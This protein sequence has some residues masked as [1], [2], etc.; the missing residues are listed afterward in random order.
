MNSYADFLRRLKEERLSLDISQSEISRMIGMNY[1][2]FCKAENHIR[3]FSYSEMQS[4]CNTALDIYY[5]YTGNRCNQYNQDLFKNASYDQIVIILKI[6]HYMASIK[7]EQLSFDYIYNN[8]LYIEY[9]DKVVSGREN[10]FKAIRH[11]YEITQ[12]EFVNTHL[13][14][15]IKKFRELECNNIFPDSELVFDMYDKYH[16]SP[17]IL[18]Q[19]KNYLQHEITYL[20]ESSDDEVKRILLYLIQLLVSKDK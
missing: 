6:F 9:P 5:C 18:L 13:S 17:G 7:R 8:T 11:Y 2:H 14:V 1:N 20:V 16:V 10:I 4:L 19:N 12:V 3:L 15:D